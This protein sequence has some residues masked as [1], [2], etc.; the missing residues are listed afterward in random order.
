MEQ[1]KKLDG[2][3]NY[4]ISDHGRI[5]NDR[6]DRILKTFVNTCGYN[7]IGLYKDGRIIKYKIS[8]LVALTFI[9]NNDTIKKIH[10]DHI[11]RDRINDNCTNLRWVDPSTNLRNRSQT[12]NRDLPNGVYKLKNGV[13]KGYFVDDQFNKKTKSFSVSK[14]GNDEALKY[15]IEFR[16]SGVEQYYNRC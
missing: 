14:Y 7:Q 3:K 13:Y 11:D 5:R 1:W 2:F 9:E 6:T 15:A 12:I 16:N 8:R 10:V 4:S